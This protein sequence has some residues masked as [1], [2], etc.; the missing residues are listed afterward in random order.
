[1]T[2][3]QLLTRVEAFQNS[4]VD[5]A[6]GG[7]KNDETGELYD[8]QRQAL[9]REPAIQDD[10]PRFIRTCRSLSQFW[11]HIKK[12]D[13]T[14]QGRR[15]YL[16]GEFRPLFDRLDANHTS[17][18]DASISTSLQKLNAAHVREAWDKALS[19]RHEDPEGAITSARTLLETVCKHILDAED[20]A[21]KSD[22]NLSDL[23]K[24]TAKG[25]NLAPEQHQE[26]VFK[27]ILSGC[28]TVVGGLAA[29]R[30]G[31]SD[32]HGKPTRAVKPAPRHA[33]LAVDLA[34]SVSA[35]FVDTWEARQDV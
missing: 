26:P 2:N 24:A 5:I 10:L 8:S 15:D 35:F 12:Q 25:L 9:L 29:L 32:A 4:L 21:Y 19:R 30:N 3:D 23:C 16:W 13:G 7:P 34:G 33:R 11:E 28:Y 31:L 27:Q 22:W 6:T 14:Y 17:P 20:I 1:M 18:A